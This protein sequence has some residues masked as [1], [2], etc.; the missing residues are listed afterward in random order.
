MDQESMRK[1]IN[2]INESVLR[3]E[4]ADEQE[5]WEKW[6]EPAKIDPSERGK[7]EGRTKAELLKS[8]NALK[9]SGPHRKG[10]KDYDRMKELAFAIRAKSGWGNVKE[11]EIGEDML[12]TTQIEEKWGVQTKTK[13]KD[14]G[15]WEGWT[16]AELRARKKKLMDKPSRSA[17]ETK[18][19]RQI[20]FA[21]RA[22]TGWGKAKE[23]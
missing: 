10:S 9:A 5:V 7:Y 16:L 15:K 23:Q 17:A 4:R 19:V 2:I 1:Y 20:N 18:E 22:K 14:K 8:Y 11:Y 21:I 13:E 12:R 3:R 6:K